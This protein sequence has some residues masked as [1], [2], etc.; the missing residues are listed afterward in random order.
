MTVNSVIFRLS[1]LAW[2]LWKQ[3]WKP[4]M[5]PTS[6]ISWTCKWSKINQQWSPLQTLVMQHAWE[7]VA[8]RR[9]SNLSYDRYIDHWSVQPLLVWTHAKS[10]WTASALSISLENGEKVSVNKCK[11]TRIFT[12]I[13]ALSSFFSKKI[14]VKEA[15][16]SLQHWQASAKAGSDSFLSWTARN[17]WEGEGLYSVGYI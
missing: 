17:K 3:T 9:H 5:V 8:L 13:G 15:K 16:P 1:T 6:K 7:T 4:L 11:L 14:H 2:M 12:D 10:P